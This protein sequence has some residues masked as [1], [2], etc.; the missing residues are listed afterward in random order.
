M[1]AVHNYAN[2]KVAKYLRRDNDINGLGSDCKSPALICKLFP[3]RLEPV[4][5]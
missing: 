3:W 5:A 4:R 1:V 2:K